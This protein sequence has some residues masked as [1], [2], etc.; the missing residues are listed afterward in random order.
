MRGAVTL[1]IL[2]M[3]LMYLYDGVASVVRTVCGVLWAEVECT[4]GCCV[5]SF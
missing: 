2:N 1:N 4:R 3:I 5:R